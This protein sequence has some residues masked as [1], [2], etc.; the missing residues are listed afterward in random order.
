LD[1]LYKP[2]RAKVYFGE[3][4]YVSSRANVRQMLLD[5]LEFFDDHL[6]PGS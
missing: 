2:H 4:Y 5:M 6:R 3:N 1:R